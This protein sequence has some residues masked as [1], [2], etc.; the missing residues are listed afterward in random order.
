ME[1]IKSGIA[2]IDEIIGGIPAGRT[3]LVTGEPG[4][5]KT[6]LGLQFA[7][8][9]CD[10]G[11]KT[12]YI[13]SEEDAGDLKFQAKGLGWD[14]DAL[15][16]KDLLSIVELT[17][18]RVESIDR[19][20]KMATAVR[21]G[22]F[23]NVLEHAPDETQVLV[24]DSLGTYAAKVDQYQFKDQLDLLVYMLKELDVTALIILDAATSRNFQDSAEYAVYGALRL[25]KRDNPYTGERE[26]A[27]DVVKMR[28]TKTPIKLLPYEIG[29]DGIA[30]TTGQS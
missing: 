6:I 3:V 21:T 19:A 24:F 14:L 4:C 8:S 15:E 12:V 9:C 22:Q 29:K 17:G 7:R 13:T 27:I 23:S 16:K 25:V 1:R 11:L 20:N 18:K 26:R 28:G 30:L 10:Q 2:G 5:G